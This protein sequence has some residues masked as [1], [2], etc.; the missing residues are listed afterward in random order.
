[1]QLK[2][3][4]LDK[5]ELTDET[6]DHFGHILHRIRALRDIPRHNV[7]AGDLGGFI[8]SGANLSQEGDCWVGEVRGDAQVSGNAWVRDNAQ[9]FGNA[10]IYGNAWVFGNAQVFSDAQVSGAARVS[11]NACV[12]GD[13]Q[14]SGNAHVYGYAWV[15]DDACVFTG[16]YAEG[17]ICN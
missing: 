7:K 17:E 15:H 11:G 13:A 8:E 6:I 1:M 4:S 2:L 14:V 10:Q 3:F 9:V 5:Y 16:I 12:S